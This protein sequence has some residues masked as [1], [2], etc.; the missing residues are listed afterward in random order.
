MSVDAR[1]E[2]SSR[3]TVKDV[4]TILETQCDATNVT[5]EQGLPSDTSFHVIFFDL[6]IHGKCRL[7][8]HAALANPIAPCLCITAYHLLAPIIEKI[9]TIL[10]GYFCESDAEGTRRFLPGKFWDENGLT[11]FLKYGLLHGTISEGT[12]S[13]MINTLTDTLK[14]WD[15]KYGR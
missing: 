3:W 9:G 5:I 10:G 6:P 15:E 13:A 4:V 2:T 11:Y 14:S 1:L 7:N 8:A 12:H